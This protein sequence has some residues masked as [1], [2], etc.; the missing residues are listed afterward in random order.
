MGQV[1][2]QEYLYFYNLDIESFS[3]CFIQLENLKDKEL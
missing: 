1:W 2:W 3:Q